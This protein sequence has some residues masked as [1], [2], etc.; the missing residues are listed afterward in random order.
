LPATRSIVSYLTKRAPQPVMDFV[1]QHRFHPLVRPF[2]NLA[3]RGLGATTDGVEIVRGPLA[4]MILAF[5]DVP[6]EWSGIHEPEVQSFLLSEIKPGDI[7]YD[8]GAHVGYFVLLAARALGGE[9][10]IVAYEPEPRSFELMSQ[11]VAANGLEELVIRRP[12]ALGD[13]PGRG[14]IGYEDSSSYAQIQLSE[15]GSIQVRTL[16][17]EV[18]DGLPEPSF[19]MLDTEGFEEKI[20]AGATR[21][22]SRS[23]PRILAEHHQRHDELVEHLASYG[24]S[25]HDV[26]SGHIFFSIGS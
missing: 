25:H 8:I 21:V 2:R 4:G 11:T 20:F 7:V 16:D 13:V 26:D 3:L 10:R 17:E 12:V 18:E 1:Y 6:A 14:S 15:G 24:Y 23:R 9:G 19:L 5:E 22:L